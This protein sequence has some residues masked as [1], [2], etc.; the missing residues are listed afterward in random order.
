MSTRILIASNNP[1]KLSEFRRILLPLGLEPVRPAE[2]GIELE[3]DETGSTFAENAALKAEAFSRVAR[4][5]A[6]A[7]DSG[8]VVDALGG[9]PGVLSARYGGPGLSD[10][11]RV[12][13]L[14]RRMQDV[15]DNQRTARFVAAIALARPGD[16]TFAVQ[17]LVDGQ[18]TRAPRGHR[19]FGY[20]PVFLY[21]PFGRT[22]AEVEPEEKDRVSHRGK[23]MRRMARVLAGTGSG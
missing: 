11:D 12:Q 4:L 2:L 1:H 18:I 8:L 10:A 21:P 13:L 20:D 15:P 17:E 16:Q 14:L 23:A 3:V 19:G 22:F 7:D 6:L 9:E 5:P